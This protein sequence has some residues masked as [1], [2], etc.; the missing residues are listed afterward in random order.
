MVLHSHPLPVGGVHCLFLELP[1][2][3]GCFEV[4]HTTLPHLGAVLGVS[5]MHTIAGRASSLL[6]CLACRCYLM[7]AIMQSFRK[8]RDRVT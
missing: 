4:Q 6:S 5:L 2:P 1:G 7:E 3:L 8:R